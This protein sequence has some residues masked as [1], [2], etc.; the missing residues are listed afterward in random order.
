MPKIVNHD[1]YRK[2][3]IA[4]CMDLFGR[5]GYDNVTM[6]EIAAELDVS[7][8]TLY[9][10]FPTKQSLFEQMFEQE[11][12]VDVE[13]ALRGMNGIAALRER[14][15]RLNV[16]WGDRKEYYQNVLLLAIDFF[17]S[18]G[19]VPDQKVLVSF[20][21]Y[22]RK[23]MSESLEIP[24]PEASL[25]FIFVIGLMYHSLLGPAGVD[26]NEQLELMRDILTS[27]HS[28]KKDGSM[29]PSP[30][31]GEGRGGGEKA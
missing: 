9:H 22:Y 27:Y 15:E 21:E 5:K 12:R 24:L 4:R 7:T 28:E 13:E 6:R 3:L 25:L 14:L 23:A 31:R 8:G 16:H 2:E 30:L 17:R 18:N 26:F 19:A 20:S 29:S 11:R 10:Y 1:E